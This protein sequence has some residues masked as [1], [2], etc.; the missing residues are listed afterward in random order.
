M[1]TIQVTMSRP[2]SL[3]SYMSNTLLHNSYESGLHLKDFYSQRHRHAAWVI[4]VSGATPELTPTFLYPAYSRSARGPETV[5]MSGP[6]ASGMG[7]ATSVWGS[8][9]L[10]QS[11][12]RCRSRQH[13]A[14]SHPGVMGSR[15]WVEIHPEM[16]L[17][18]RLDV[19]VQG[20]P[21]PR[22]VGCA[23]LSW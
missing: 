20:T 12:M 13:Q 22:C 1:Y 15:I 3:L 6:S 9:P 19:L 16:P 10:L 11:R 4:V 7:D 14:P 2:F 17:R 21:R 18:V 5:R 23:L 8:P